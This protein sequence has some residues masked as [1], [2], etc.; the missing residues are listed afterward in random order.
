MLGTYALAGGLVSLVGW[1]ANIP[2]LTDWAG[3]G[4]SIMPNATVCAA[5]AGAALI[6]LSFSNRQWPVKFLGVFVGL[7][8]AATLFEY[9]TGVNL[10]IDKALIYRE[11]GQRGTVSPGRMGP[12]A[13]TAWTI[14]GLAFVLASGG[15]KMRRGAV[16][17][18]LVVTSIA[19]L[20]LVGYLFG[21]ELLY[22]IPRLTTIALQTSSMIFALS[23]GIVI[24]IHDHQPMKT[25]RAGNTAGLLARSALPYIIFMPLVLGWLRV[26]GQQAGLFDTAFG[27]A[28][29]VLVH[30]GL[31]LVLLWWAVAKVATKESA[32]SQSEEF[33]R[34]IIESSPECIKTL[35]HEG[36]FLSMSEQGQKLFGI[37]DFKPYLSQSWSEL[38]GGKDREAAEA[39]VKA[40][41][42]GQTTS[43]IGFL[44]TVPG[45][46][47][48]WEVV[49]SPVRDE[50]GKVE[51]LLAVS[52][53]IT[54]RKQAEM[55]MAFLA[56]VSLDLVRLE[57][58]EEIMHKVGAKIGG[59]FH[60]S[61]CNF[62][63]VHDALGEVVVTHD[64][65]RDNVP[66]TVGVYKL[67]EFLTE[68]FQNTLRAGEVFVVRDTESDPRTDAGKYAAL[69][70]RSFVCMPLLRDGK[71]EF[72]LN[73]HD[74]VPR[75]W[76]EDEIQLLR[77]VT[78]RIWTRLER[79]RA[80][81]KL[82]AT[83]A[84][85]ETVNTA[86]PDMIF[87]KDRAGRMTYLNEA[88]R[89]VIGKPSDQILGRTELEWAGDT[90]FSRTVMA[91]DQRIMASGV[92]ESVEETSP[93]GQRIFLVTK[94]TR[95]DAQGQVVGMVG[96][97]VDIT[98][99]KRTEQVLRESEEQFRAMAD[100]IASLAWMANPDGWIFFYNRRWYDYT[101]TT[102]EE[103][104][105]WGWEKVH[106]PNHLERMLPTWEKALATGEPWED[107]FPLRR[108]DGKYGWFLSRAFPIRNAEGKITRWFGTNT[109]ITE[110]RETEAK[111]AEAN[112]L[113]SDRA[114]HLEKTVAERTVALKEINDQLEAFVYSIAH[115]LR[116]PLRSMQGFSQILMEGHGGTLN[117]DAR[118][119]LSRI[120]KSAE[121]MD[122]LIM[123]LLAFGRAGRAEIEFEPV[124][125]QKA[126]SNALFQS[127][128]EIEK[129]NAQIEAV[130]PFPSVRA[131][132]ATLSQVLANLLSN[133]L[134]FM[135]S[136]V[137]PH[138]RFWTEED[139]GS[140]RLWVQ[141]NGVGIPKEYQERIF[142]VFERL[143]GAHYPGTG[144]GLSIVRKG[145]ERMNG[146]VGVESEPGKGSRFWIELPKA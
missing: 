11:W 37:A 109:D 29:L 57:T 144:V 63:E 106:H 1:F 102:F 91:N 90:L 75:D 27:S 137:Q 127:A 50:S 3:N 59:H 67:E 117:E 120:N 49:V 8:G 93:D 131:H 46:P 87:A 107:I 95:R 26:R 62:V 31:L 126:W 82:S 79:V 43:F 65:H 116:S 23:I 30:T 121:F 70:L 17:C 32:L 86:T 78:T 92:T 39:A 130:P 74:S 51:R 14:I 110:L 114:K 35:D 33:N 89:A 143:Q 139:G 28:M 66:G 80:E 76:Q 60:L 128:T 138:I 36:R 134:K 6:F 38:W 58:V 4:I 113:L 9:F 83:L 124:D 47:K 25:L 18:A 77:E 123:D 22:T 84:L 111:L 115:D 15:W 40:A 20:S 45:E 69:Q 145:V 99:R 54:V 56:S 12:P 108:T 41:V 53:D 10:G 105:G 133:A 42:A 140:V 122:K 52:R 132:E 72:M 96:V 44:K 2:R 141:D 146:K 48:W 103:M 73:V 64:W 101:G 104:Q 97:G 55:N 112:E 142:R 85:L 100:N 94:A 19:T 119:Y 7:I 81:K 125:L 68:D 118:N 61:L 136:G 16:V 71:W 129:T 5:C 135:P 13:S 24:T 21:T 88:T 34:S 98:E